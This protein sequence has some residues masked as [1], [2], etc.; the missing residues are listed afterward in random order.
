MKLHIGNYFA[1][2]LCVMCQNGVTDSEK[3][4]F[5]MLLLIYKGFAWNGKDI[6]AC[7]KG[8]YILKT[9]RHLEALIAYHQMV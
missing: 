9:L 1:S 8:V 3:N 7:L 2:N 6:Y 4:M 5:L